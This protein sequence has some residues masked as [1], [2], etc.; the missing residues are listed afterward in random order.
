MD[1]Q[2]LLTLEEATLDDLDTILEIEAR[3]YPVPWSRE[4]MID[5]FNQK[6]IRMKLLMNGELIGY[7]FV[8]IILDEGHLLHITVD[9]IHHGKRL[10]RYLLEHVLQL[11]DSH[12]LATIFLEVREG[13]TP[14]RALYDRI[15][16]NQVGVRK[17]YYPCKINGRE[18]AIVMAYT[19]P[20]DTFNFQ[21]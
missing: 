14:A 2:T 8:S 1:I 5:V 12:Q 18:D 20:S 21:L 9:P 3:A 17:G 7:A 13:N 19:V 15:G 4:Q 6:V 16:F 10:G 11:G